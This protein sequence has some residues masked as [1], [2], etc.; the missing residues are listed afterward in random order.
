MTDEKS[1]KEHRHNTERLSKE[2][3]DRLVQGV[4]D[5]YFGGKEQTQSPEQRP[6]EMPKE[7]PKRAEDSN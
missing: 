7:E 2:E 4:D 1:K 3:I 6:I 5:I